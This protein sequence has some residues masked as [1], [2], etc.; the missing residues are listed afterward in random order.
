MVK[1]TLKFFLGIISLPICVAISASLYDELNQIKAISHNQKYFLF[2]VIAYLIIH[3]AFFKPEYLYILGHEI[4]H[5]IACWI[6]RGRVTSFRVS[7]KGGQVTT[8]KSNLLIALAPYFFPFYTIMVAGV[9][10]IIPLFIKTEPPYTAFLF[11]VG[12]TFAFHIILTIDF[13]KTRQTD[14]LPAGYLFSI[15]LVY[16]VNLVVIGLIFSLLFGEI[17]FVE[18]LKSTYFRSKDIY[19]AVFRQLFL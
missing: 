14:F 5:V 6:F 3:I 1:R 13:L 12:F 4:M 17:N 7:S 11:L 16:I 10:L 18:F 15:C 2:G 8:T 19:L 9:F